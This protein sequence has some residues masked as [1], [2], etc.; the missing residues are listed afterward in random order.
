MKSPFK[1]LASLLILLLVVSCN[2]VSKEKTSKDFPNQELPSHDEKK[3]SNKFIGK[4]YSRSSTNSFGYQ[5]QTFSFEKNGKGTFISSHSTEVPIAIQRKYNRYSNAIN[6]EDRGELFWEII[7]G[8]IHI[9]YT[10]HASDGVVTREKAI[11]DYD[12]V[13]NKLISTE[14]DSEVYLC[15]STNKSEI[16]R[17]DEYNSNVED[18]TI[19]GDGPTVS[20]EDSP[21][22][23]FGEIWRN[24]ER[25]YISED[26]K[27]M[28]QIRSDI[29]NENNLI[30]D[31]SAFGED[32]SS[33][34]KNFIQKG[35]IVTIQ[36]DN[37][38][39]TEYWDKRLEVKDNASGEIQVYKVWY[40]PG[41]YK[42]RSGRK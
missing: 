42:W 8:E 10:Y 36:V 22:D 13:K 34:S 21:E 27:S 37:L 17:N 24:G 5:T 29:D 11:F 31:Y 39:F 25:H 20:I 15:V 9:N 7:D 35:N 3:V 2:N 41:N 28:Y 30:I 26:R 18:E 19:E 33:D 12:E 40:R 4:T 38:I 16:D 32:W 14:Y 1:F 6:H 23:Y